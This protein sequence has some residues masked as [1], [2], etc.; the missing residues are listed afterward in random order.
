MRLHV[1]QAYLHRLPC[2]LN[3]ECAVGACAVQGGTYEG[4]WSQG[5]M[6]GVGVRTF[7]T[8]QVR[9]VRDSSSGRGSSVR[10]H[11]R[12]RT[13]MC[14]CVCVSWWTWVDCGSCLG[15]RN[16]GGSH[17][18]TATAKSSLSGISTA[19]AG[20]GGN[21]APVLWG[22]QLLQ[23]RP[24]R[25]KCVCARACVC[26]TVQ[27]SAVSCFAVQFALHCTEVRSG[28]REVLAVLGKSHTAVPALPQ[29]DS[30]AT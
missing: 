25:D 10:V 15:G 29:M 6:E 9:H 19:P 14:V 5:T 16:A 3:G 2:A 17:A 22:R 1:M 21:Q 27:R 4:E 7:S 26:T 11:V 18:L 20:V 8:G 12:V 24:C 13:R 30:Q 28:H 23:L